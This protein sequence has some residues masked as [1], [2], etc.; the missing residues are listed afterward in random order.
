MTNP[1]KLESGMLLLDP[2]SRTVYAVVS[3]KTVIAHHGSCSE[4]AT[5]SR[6]GLPK[7]WR[8]I[9]NRALGGSGETIGETLAGRLTDG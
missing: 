5:L 7:G 9:N 8:V 4:R 2:E 1:T 3:A 6:S